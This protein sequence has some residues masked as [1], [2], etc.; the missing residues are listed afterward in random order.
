MITASKSTMRRHVHECGGYYSRAS[1]RWCIPGAQSNCT[2]WASDT[3]WYASLE[4][5]YEDASRAAEANRQV[6]AFGDAEHAMLAR[7]RVG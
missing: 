3:M 5:A 2:P 1:G 7:Y 6:H 4:D